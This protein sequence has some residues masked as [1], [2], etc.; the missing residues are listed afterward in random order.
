MTFWSVENY[1]LKPDFTFIN[2]QKVFS[3]R[4]FYD[5]YLRTLGYALTAAMITSG[6][7][8]RLL[9]K[10]GSMQGVTSGQSRSSCWFVLSS[11]ATWS[12]RIHGRS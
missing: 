7:P 2:W 1:R 6:S 11:P 4:Y 3:T 5:I 9:T 10:L 12:A 8:V